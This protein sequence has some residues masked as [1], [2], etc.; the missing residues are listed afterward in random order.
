MGRSHHQW[1]SSQIWNTRT[2]CTG[3]FDY[4]P[5]VTQGGTR[6]PLI[7]THSKD[8]RTS[9]RE[10]LKVGKRHCYQAKAQCCSVSFPR[11]PDEDTSSE[12]CKENNYTCFRQ[13]S[14]QSMA[15]GEPTRAMNIPA[16]PSSWSPTPIPSASLQSQLSGFGNQRP[17]CVGC[18]LKARRALRGT[19]Q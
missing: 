13:P 4:L 19:S 15:D 9:G 16:I 11:C 17:W 2:A 3:G 12:H 1:W 7:W 14:G 18:Q 5:N 10:Q 8:Q 6:M